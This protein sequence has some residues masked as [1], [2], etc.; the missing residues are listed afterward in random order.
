MEQQRFVA[1]LGQLT[2]PTAF[3]PDNFGFLPPE[4]CALCADVLGIGTMVSP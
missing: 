3:L 4:N 2:T 1:C